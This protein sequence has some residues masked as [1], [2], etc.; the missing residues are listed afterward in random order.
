M[1]YS[2]LQPEALDAT[3]ERICI[4]ARVTA[5]SMRPPFRPGKV[6]AMICMAILG[7]SVKSIAEMSGDSLARTR[8]VVGELSTY[9]SCVDRTP[10]MGIVMAQYPKTEAVLMGVEVHRV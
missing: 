3:L 4:R 7:Y 8:K 2:N 6:K 9:A 1:I 5:E 10:A